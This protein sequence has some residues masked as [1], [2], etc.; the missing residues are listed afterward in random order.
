MFGIQW[1][2]VL[3]FIEAKGIKTKNEIIGN[4]SS[5]GN[6]SNS[7]FNVER[8]KYSIDSGKTYEQIRESYSKESS[9]NILLT[10]G[11]TDRNS[12]LGIY[13]LAGNVL[14]RTLEYSN[15]ESKPCCMAGGF[16]SSGGFDFPPTERMYHAVST[17]A[18]GV[19]FRTAL[20]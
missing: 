15:L 13:D 19:G 4:S 1:N 2:L 7:A 5:W 17:A 14:E 9:T 20:W 16:F 12:A 3:K 6:H 18:P 10:T 11:A 8:G